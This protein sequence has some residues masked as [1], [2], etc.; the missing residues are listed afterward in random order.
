[1]LRL[2]ENT[3]I[4]PVTFPLLRI[5]TLYSHILNST[6]SCPFL[7]KPFYI[8]SAFLT[9]DLFLTFHRF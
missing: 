5:G 7:N 8:L 3:G 6:H 9:L 4:E 2:V 1:M